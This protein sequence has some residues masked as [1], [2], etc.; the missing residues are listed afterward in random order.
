M[1]FCFTAKTSKVNALQ[2][3]TCYTVQYFVFS[4][5]DWFDVGRLGGEDAD[6]QIVKEE[7]Q[8]NILSMLHQ[9]RGY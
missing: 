7:Q 5:T 2:K 4:F 1:R 8:K 3:I 9:V 6:K